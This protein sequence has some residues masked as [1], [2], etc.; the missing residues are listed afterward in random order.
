MI[1]INAY[2]LE[3]TEE[4]MCSNIMKTWASLQGSYKHA[5]QALNKDLMFQKR[6]QIVGKKNI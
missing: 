2:L 4:R 1:H 3:I 5:Q 6:S